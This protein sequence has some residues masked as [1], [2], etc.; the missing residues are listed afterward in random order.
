MRDA[1]YSLFGGERRPFARAHF[2]ELRLEATPQPAVEPIKIDIDDRRNVER[3]QLRKD[4][5]ADDGD[6]ERF[7]GL[8]IRRLDSLRLQD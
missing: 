3:Q 4:E 1:G 6:A 2:L 8:A 5:T 7:Q